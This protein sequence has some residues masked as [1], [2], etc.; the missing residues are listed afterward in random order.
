MYLSQSSASTTPPQDK[1]LV[2]HSPPLSPPGA[3]LLRP[4]LANAL[5]SPLPPWPSVCPDFHDSWVV[6]CYFGCPF[7]INIISMHD[8]TA[9]NTYI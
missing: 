8:K 7:V 2:Q 1:G 6:T 9:G 3:G 4:A 5:L